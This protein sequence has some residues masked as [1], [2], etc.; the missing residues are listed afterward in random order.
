M[1][2]KM[3]LM[4][5][6][7][8]T[9][10]VA[11]CATDQV[12]RQPT[13]FDRSKFHIGGYYLMKCA[14]DE[15]HI[16]DV[17]DCGIDY[18]YGIE[19]NPPQMREVFDLFG[20]YGLTAFIGGWP[21]PK[22]ATR[23]KFAE[24][25]PLEKLDECAEQIRAN[26]YLDYPAYQGV[27]TGDEPSA[28]DFPHL[29]K[30]IAREQELMPD[31][32]PYLNLYPS[33]ATVYEDEGA[34]SKSQLG[35]RS[36]REYI[37]LYC[38]YIPLDYISLDFYLYGPPDEHLLDRFYSNCQIVADACRRTDREFWFIPQVNSRRADDP[39]SVNKL[40]F[41]AYS[42]MAFGCVNL[43]WACYSTGWWTNNVLDRAGN[44]SVQYEKL[45]Q[46]NG[47]IRR[48][49]PK[50]MRFRN[51]A[52]EYV[53]FD[54]QPE[55]LKLVTEKKPVKSLDFCQFKD[56]C[57]E[58]RKALLVGCMTPRKGDS[59]VRA[60][61]VCAADDPFDKAQKSRTVKFRC[62]SRRI[63]AFG[64]HGKVELKKLAHGVYSFPIESN[65]AVFVVAD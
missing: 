40:R 12:N 61:F 48:V 59:D 15:D 19:A 42:A 47:E 51:V 64:G 27:Y 54:S 2:M 41:Q 60:L 57:A 4:A 65:E 50:F 52:T 33:Y 9:V 25:T 1:E 17:R 63:R 29:G 28:V 31:L 21:N 32:L 39:P 11:G 14:I 22:P 44:K 7:L 45:K 18:I 62:E 53:G 3:G 8:A 43:N 38:K 56:L 23:G 55:A 26:G 46:V 16:R 34:S 37:D 10:A 35:T 6:A 5:I 49:A 24:T 36:Y 58:D 13:R 30:V 20:K